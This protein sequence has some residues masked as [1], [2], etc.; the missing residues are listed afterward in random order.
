VSFCRVVVTVLLLVGCSAPVADK[1][2]GSAPPHMRPALVGESS[3]IYFTFRNTSADTAILI[4]VDVD[5]ASNATMHRSM[6]QHN[7]ASMMPIDSIVVAPNDS[8]VF[9]ERGLHV[10]AT[11]LRAPIAIGDTVVARLRM[12]SARVDTIRVAVRE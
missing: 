6:E 8:V 4:G 3:A 1:R 10:M 5:V 7:M 11:G 12:R 9:A 2:T